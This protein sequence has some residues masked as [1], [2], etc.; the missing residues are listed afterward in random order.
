MR[1]AH[2]ETTRNGNLSRHNSTHLLCFTMPCTVDTVPCWT[3]ARTHPPFSS[4]VRTQVREGDARTFVGTAVYMSPERMLGQSYSF[5]SDIWSLGPK[6]KKRGCGP[7]Q[8]A[9]PMA[10]VKSRP[11][12]RMRLPMVAW[13]P[14]QQP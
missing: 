13:R 2:H 3:R 14:Y 6:R 12:P 10:A 11:S 9:A 7:C 1:A 8:P 4:R 5:T